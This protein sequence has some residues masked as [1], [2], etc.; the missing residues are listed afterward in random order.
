MNGR[1]PDA[2]MQRMQ[3]TTRAHSAHARRGA[4]ASI[5]SKG[6]GNPWMQ[7]GGE[8][9]VSDTDWSAS[10]LVRV[11]L[12]T[13][14][15]ETALFWVL[16]GRARLRELGDTVNDEG[17]VDNLAV[18]AHVLWEAL[19]EDMRFQ[20][21]R[22]DIFQETE[23]SSRTCS[24]CGLTRASTWRRATILG[25]N[26]RGAGRRA[27]RWHPPPPVHPVTV[28]W[29]AAAE[30][31]STGDAEGEWRGRWQ[32][33]DGAVRQARR[34]LDQDDNGLDSVWLESVEIADD[35]ITRHEK[36]A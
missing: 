25:R 14:D 34:W 1:F 4:A 20:W 27:A 8:G 29:R 16:S 23:T 17:P 13:E 24:T 11:T 19:P 32:T 12:T 36:L 7:R 10:N 35:A 3:S 9:L 6:R 18:A 21:P 30:A 5:A 28:L 33:H 2:W 15:V 22:D 31:Y 26:E